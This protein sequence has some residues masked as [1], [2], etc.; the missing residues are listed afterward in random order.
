MKTI[1]KRAARALGGFLFALGSRLLAFG[2]DW[3][4]VVRRHDTWR[5]TIPD[6]TA[7]RPKHSWN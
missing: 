5:D 7:R 1:L 2:Y 6:E 4:E 3:Q